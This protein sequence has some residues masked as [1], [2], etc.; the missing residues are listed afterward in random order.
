[1]PEEFRQRRPR[2]SA[3]SRSRRCGRSTRSPNSQVS[4]RRRDLGHPILI[5]ISAM[6]SVTR[7]GAPLL[8]RFCEKWESTDAITR[9]KSTSMMD[10]FCGHP[11]PSTPSPCSCS[12]FRDVRVVGS[13]HLAAAVLVSPCGTGRARLWGDGQD[14]LM[15]RAQ[16][17]RDV[18]RIRQLRLGRRPSRTA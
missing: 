9:N 11:T 10:D 15:V 12:I 7:G 16:P 2:A 8:A 18:P 13:V 4:Q 6:R 14:R 5:W 1:M 17:M 3:A